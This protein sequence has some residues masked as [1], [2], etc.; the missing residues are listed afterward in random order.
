MQSLPVLPTYISY[1]EVQGFKIKEIQG[2][3]LIPEDKNIATVVVDS[4]WLIRH[5]PQIGG[6]FVIYDERYSSFSTAE[7]FENLYSLKQ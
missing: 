7:A 4:K 6:Y 2:R 3:S 5:K 1:K